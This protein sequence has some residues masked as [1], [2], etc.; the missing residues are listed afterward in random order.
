[1]CFGELDGAENDAAVENDGND[2]PEQGADRAEEQDRIEV[3]FFRTN[4]GHGQVEEDSDEAS[5]AADGVDDAGGFVE[6][7]N[8]RE[9]KADDGDG[10]EEGE[11]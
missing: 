7:S 9:A 2:K 3:W 5:C 8:E 4:S 10:G 1:M 6:R 11:Q